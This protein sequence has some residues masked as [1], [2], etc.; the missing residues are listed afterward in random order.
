MTIL[1]SQ[2]ALGVPYCYFMV[3]QGSPCPSGIDMGSQVPQA[4]EASA[5]TTEPS[6]EP[7]YRQKSPLNTLFFLNLNVFL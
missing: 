6:P 2:L 7:I 3:P 1:T 5:V 4:C